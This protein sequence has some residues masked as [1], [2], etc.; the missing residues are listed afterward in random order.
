MM[1]GL[2]TLFGG[3]TIAKNC[4]TEMTKNTKREKKREQA[5][6][7]W[8]DTPALNPRYKGATPGDVVRALLRKHLDL[9]DQQD[10]ADAGPVK[11]K[12]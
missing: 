6:R 11:P 5:L 12:V 4:E 10:R 8:S 2:T 3:T 1:L 9:A 7:E